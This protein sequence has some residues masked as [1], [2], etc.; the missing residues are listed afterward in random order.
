VIAVR[1]PQHVE[2]WLEEL[3]RKTGRSKT[4]YVREAIFQRL[5]DL[6]DYY[7]VP[8]RLKRNLPD[9]PLGGRVPSLPGGLRRDYRPQAAA[10]FKIQ[11]TADDSA[12]VVKSMSEGWGSAYP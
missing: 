3:A 5:N 11:S 9:I 4:F 10:N 6:E 2:R 1:L 8:Q 12:C 7:L